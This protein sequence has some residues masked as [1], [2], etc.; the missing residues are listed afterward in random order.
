MP[1]GRVTAQTYIVKT[2]ASR[3]KLRFVYRALTFV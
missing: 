1:E 2:K 3:D